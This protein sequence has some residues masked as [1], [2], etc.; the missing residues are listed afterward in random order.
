M[1]ESVTTHDR[2]RGDRP[3]ECPK[4]RFDIRG[5]GV[6]D[7]VVRCPECGES[8][9]IMHVAVQT[10][11]QRTG[12]R[13]DWFRMLVASA[14]NP[15]RVAS[16]VSRH[17]RRS[18]VLVN[19]IALGVVMFV[20]FALCV[21]LPEFM[22]GAVILNLVAVGALAAAGWLLLPRGI[23]G[24]RRSEYLGH[25]LFPVVFASLVAVPVWVLSWLGFMAWTFAWLLDDEGPFVHPRLV[26]VPAL[27]C[28]AVGWLLGVRLLL[29][30]RRFLGDDPMRIGSGRRPGPV[31]GRDGEAASTSPASS[32]TDDPG[33]RA[34]TPGEA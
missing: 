9:D 23:D 20:P 10:P 28:F 2:R 31:R 29:H 17:T 25:A 6:E 12:R 7:G 15:E 11:W 32:V 13:R 5:T 16:R 1:P 14:G 3:M 8:F 26:V 21:P 22:L 4:C 27:L 34:S 24:G 30:A 33:D 19:W 18:T